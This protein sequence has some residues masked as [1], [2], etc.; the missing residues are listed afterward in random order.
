LVRIVIT[1]VGPASSTIMALGGA[2]VRLAHVKL[3]R[4]PQQPARILT[5]VAPL[6]IWRE[7][8]GVYRESSVPDV[9]PTRCGR[10]PFR[11]AFSA[12][13]SLVYPRSGGRFS[14]SSVPPQ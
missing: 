6:L 8:S 1:L 5:H 2:T 3:K 9:A 10:P 13:P 4:T 11:L 12:R 14:T 7:V